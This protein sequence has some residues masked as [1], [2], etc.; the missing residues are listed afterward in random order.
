[1]QTL[2]CNGNLDVITY[3][4]AQTGEAPFPDFDVNHKCRDFDAIVAWQE[5][6]S[7]PLEWGRNVTRPPGAKVLPMPKDW[8]RI[9]ASKQDG[10][11]D[12]DHVD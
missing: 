6:H 11:D 1:M 4:W 2:M 7:V 10:V 3:N 12:H 9:S 8:E 5:E